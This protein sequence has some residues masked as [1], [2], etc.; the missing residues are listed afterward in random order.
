M[1]SITIDDVVLA[2]QNVRRA[3]YNPDYCYPLCTLRFKNGEEYT[4]TYGQH[5]AWYLT[6]ETDPSDCKNLK[7]FKDKLMVAEL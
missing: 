2:I 4:I 1:V 3:G 5:N 6:Y 7:E